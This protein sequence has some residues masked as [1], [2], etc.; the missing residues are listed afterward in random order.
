MSPYMIRRKMTSADGRIDCPM[1]GQLSTDECYAVSAKP[2]PCPELSGR[3]DAEPE[4]SA[5]KE[6][7]TSMDGIPAGHKSVR[8]VQKS[9]EYTVI[10]DA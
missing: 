9:G 5:F 4:Y 10:V 6:K 3:I 1:A 7:R 8:V 2:V